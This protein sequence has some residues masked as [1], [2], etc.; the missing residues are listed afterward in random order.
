MDRELKEII[1]EL[2]LFCTQGDYLER[3]RAL[4]DRVLNLKRPEEALEA[5]LKII[6]RY[7]DEE[8]GSPG[9][10]VHAIEKCRGYEEALL[11]SIK[12]QPA[13]LSIWMLHRLMRKKPSSLYQ[14]ALK[15]ILTH[16]KTSETMIEDVE[17]LLNWLEQ[18]N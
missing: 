12:R 15:N 1:A 7:P 18:Y 2:E 13:T 9:P 3:L 8:L 17:I 6:E 4:T 14:E 5:M 16:P 11:A 10:L